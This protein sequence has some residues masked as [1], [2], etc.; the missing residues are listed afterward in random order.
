[1]FYDYKQGTGKSHIYIRVRQ[2]IIQKSKS[3]D[4]A[5]Q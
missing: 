3:E 4:G 2:Q 1:M 5:V